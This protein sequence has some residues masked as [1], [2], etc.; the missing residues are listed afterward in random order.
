LVSLTTQ[1]ILKNNIGRKCLRIFWMNTKTD[2]HL[3]QMSCVIKK[4]NSKLFYT[5]HY[6]SEQS[7]LLQDIMQELWNKM[8][9]NGYFE[10]KTITRIKRIFYIKSNQMF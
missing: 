9:K 6:P 7:M 1:L 2:V 8:V 3:T 4:L 10:G 5:M